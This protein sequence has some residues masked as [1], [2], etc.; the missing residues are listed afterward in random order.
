MDNDDVEFSEE[1]DDDLLDPMEP[2]KEVLA[3]VCIDEEESPQN[4]KATQYTIRDLSVPLK[5]VEYKS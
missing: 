2:Y 5:K 1:D 4:G 3:S